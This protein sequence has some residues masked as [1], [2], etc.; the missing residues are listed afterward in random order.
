MATRDAYQKRI[1]SHLKNWKAKL[2]QLKTRVDQTEEEVKL[3]YHEQIEMLQAKREE[4][5]K[6]LEELKV[7]GEG[8]WENVK[9]GVEF[10]W[11]E[12][13]RTANNTVS[14]FRFGSSA[15][16]RDEEIRLIAYQLWQDEGCPHGRHLEHWVKAEAIWQERQLGKKSMKQTAPKPKRTT[17]RK[18]VSK[19]ASTS[20]ARPKKKTLPPE[21][22][23]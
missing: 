15:A 17:K 13:R 16:M 2:D 22:G 19:K 5:E 7:A 10:A 18:S 12:L 1:E 9:A 20:R 14:K 23:S 8:A 11:T 6:K 4:A 3:K 21:Q